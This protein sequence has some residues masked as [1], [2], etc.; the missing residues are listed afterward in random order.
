MNFHWV[1]LGKPIPVSLS[2]LYLLYG[3]NNP[4]SEDYCK[5]IY[6]MRS[7]FHIQAILRLIIYTDSRVLFRVLCLD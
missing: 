4:N 6:S 2:L 1:A 3:G 7:T 5:E